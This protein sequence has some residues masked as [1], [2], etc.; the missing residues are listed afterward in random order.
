MLVR[1]SFGV[2]VVHI[3]QQHICI[4]KVFIILFFYRFLSFSG[5]KGTAVFVMSQYPAL[6]ISHHKPLVFAPQ[7]ADM[8]QNTRNKILQNP[9][10]GTEKTF[11]FTGFVSLEK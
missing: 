6:V 5:C 4:R 11:L 9:L 8:Q 10:S 1:I 7:V 3:R 2:R